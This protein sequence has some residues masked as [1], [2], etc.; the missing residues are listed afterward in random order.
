MQDSRTVVVML[1]AVVPQ[2]QGQAQFLEKC[3]EQGSDQRWS[4]PPPSAIQLSVRCSHYV[5]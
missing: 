3:Q 2:L 1:R 4:C 5:E